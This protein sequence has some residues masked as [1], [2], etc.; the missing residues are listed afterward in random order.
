MIVSAS[1]RT[2]IPAFYGSWFMNRLKKGFCLVE[3]PYGG[4][5][6]RVRLDRDG[7]DAFVFWTRNIGPFL[8]ALD[9]LQAKGYPFLVTYTMT[10]YP[11]SL[12]PGVPD[13]SRTLRLMAELAR[14]FGSRAL[15]WRYDPVLISTQTPED[16][17]VENFRALAGGLKG[18]TDEAVLSFA[19]IYRKTKRNLDAAARLQ[20]F[21][22]RDPKAG[23]KQALLA[24]LAEAAGEAGLRLSLCSQPDYQAPGVEAAS[25]IDSKRLMEIA[26]RSFATRLKGNRPGCACAESRDIGAYDTCPQGC[27]YCYAVQTRALARARFKAH[28][29]EGDYLFKPASAAS[30]AA[31]TELPFL[32]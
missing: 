18:V 7:V 25:C 20:D 2:D 13:A 1:Y 11:R 22:W 26:G 16:W 6:S 4:R 29:P 10:G 28:D 32:T 23:E 27:V 19:H 30:R 24:R 31:Q 21:S 8:P 5:P 9:E 3:N 12:E 14:R 15:V 17:H